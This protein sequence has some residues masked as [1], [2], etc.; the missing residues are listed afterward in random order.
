MTVILLFAADLFPSVVR[1]GGSLIISPVGMQEKI[2]S[3][4]KSCQEIDVVK[5][6]L[7]PS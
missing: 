1:S 6:L 5:N 2:M 4:K 7:N 3:K